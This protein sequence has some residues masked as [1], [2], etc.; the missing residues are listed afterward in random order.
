MDYVGYINLLEDIKINEK[1]KTLD[2]LINDDYILELIDNENWEELKRIIPKELIL[3]FIHVV[4]EGLGINLIDR[5]NLFGTI[6]PAEYFI[7]L[8]LPD[9]ISIPKGIKKIG[10]WAFSGCS[11]L[12]SITIP[13]SVTSIGDGAFAGCSSLKNINIPDS[14]TSIG[15]S[16]F[17]HCRVLKSITIPDSVTS[18][19]RYAFGYC[20]SLTNIT[21][22]ISVTSIGKHAFYG[23]S[24]LTSITIGNSVTSIGFGAFE[25]CNSLTSITI[26]N[27]VTSI[28][29][30]AF[31][32]CYQLKK[33]N[34]SGTMREWN[35][36]VAKER[37]WNRYTK[38]SEVI[39]TDGSIQL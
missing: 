37:H 22:G 12:T 16:A 25:G 23:C 6:I 2:D 36:N 11:S 21:I 31:Y 27:S 35:N 1:Y 14:V 3:N 38:F 20:S 19:G 30:G 7:N 8:N 29:E 26:P 15:N 24:S 33:F 28:G 39:C 4:Q 18:I 9:R 5:K 34:Y 13:D 10:S 32:G 17:T